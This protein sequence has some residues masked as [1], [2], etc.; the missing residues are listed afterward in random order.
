MEYLKFYS[1]RIYDQFKNLAMKIY[2]FSLTKITILHEICNEEYYN[3]Q[4]SKR[5]KITTTAN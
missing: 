5:N 1:T 2:N 4:K 3:V